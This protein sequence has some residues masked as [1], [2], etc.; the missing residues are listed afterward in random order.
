MDSYDLLISAIVSAVFSH[1]GFAPRRKLYAINDTRSPL[2]A[3]RTLVTVTCRLPASHIAYD[4]LPRALSCPLFS[5][6]M[7]TLLMQRRVQL[8][9]CLQI[10]VCASTDAR[11]IQDPTFPTHEPPDSVCVACTRG[12][13]RYCAAERRDPQAPR[14]GAC[15]FTSRYI[16]APPF[17]L[18][19][20]SFRFLA[21]RARRF[22]F[23]ADRGAASPGQVDSDDRSFIEDVELRTPLPL[24]EG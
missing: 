2:S 20:S 8:N 5:V 18:V 11:P 1:E 9:T 17:D 19:I 14:T 22:P 15:C 24:T 10:C 23:G 3:P 12:R 4:L 7:N 13:G 21:H 16:C 6:L